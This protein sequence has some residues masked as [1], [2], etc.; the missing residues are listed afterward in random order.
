MASASGNVNELSPF[1]FFWSPRSDKLIALAMAFF[2]MLFLAISASKF[3]NI[4]VS[5][6]LD[7]PFFGTL[8]T[9]YNPFFGTVKNII[10]FFGIFVLVLS[11]LRVYNAYTNGRGRT[12]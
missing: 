11:L 8:K 12:Q 9:Y 7:N 4:L 3:G 1:S 5:F 6:L 10:T 2:L